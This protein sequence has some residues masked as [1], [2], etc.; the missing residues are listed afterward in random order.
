MLHHD[1]EKIRKLLLSG[2]CG[3]EKE[4]LRIIKDG[5]FSKTPHPFPDDKYITRDFCENQLEINTGANDSVHEAFEE[6]LILEKRAADVLLSSDPQEFLWPF[7][8]PPYIK[9]EEDIPIAEFTGELSDKT[10]YRE[11][12]SEVYGRYK[13]TFCGIHFNYSL[14]EE[15]IKTDLEISGMT[16]PLEHKNRIY[17][18]MAKNLVR[19]GWI[20][21]VLLSAS[22]LLDGSFFDPNDAGKTVFL[23]MASVRCSELGY[24]NK[25]IPVLDYERMKDYADSIG[26]YIESGLL[27]SQTELYYPV[28]I[29]PEGENSL[30][31][32]VRNGADHMEIRNIDLNPFAKGGIEIKDLKF[33]QLLTVYCASVEAPELSEKE[34]TDA[35]INFRNAARFDIEGTKIRLADGDMTGLRRAASELLERMKSFFLPTGTDAGDIIDYQ[36]NKLTPGSRYA[37]RVKEEFSY[38][39]VNKGLLEFIYNK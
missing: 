35:V 31:R 18:D 16:D 20:V 17:L 1:D 26:K 9:N 39:F 12:L 25:F 2:K 21:N 23:D 28:R 14:S 30:E 36:L 11:Y 38:G 15:L 33:L 34:Q 6:L 3:L 8:N 29:K 32:L 13:M 27:S 22:P 37:E 7:S 10:R 19:N 5:S 4:T 24:W